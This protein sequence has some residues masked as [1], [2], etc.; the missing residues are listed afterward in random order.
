MVQ[1]FMFFTKGGLAHRL[2]EKTAVGWFLSLVFGK[3]MKA[4]HFVILWKSRAVVGTA[5]KNLAL[6]FRLG[7]IVWQKSRIG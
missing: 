1:F 2:A 4:M 5:P 7:K 6:F 3:R